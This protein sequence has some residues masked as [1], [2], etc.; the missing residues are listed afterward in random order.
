MALL[1]WTGIQGGLQLRWP[2]FQIIWSIR[3]GCDIYCWVGSQLT[4]VWIR[5][6]LTAWPEMGLY[7]VE[8]KANSLFS[9]KRAYSVGWES[10]H[11]CLGRKSAHCLVW[12]GFKSCRVG[13]RLIAWPEVDLYLSELEVNSS[14]GP[15]QANIVESEVDPSHIFSFLRSRV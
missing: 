10:I 2:G 5:G 15:E 11:S 13:N 9:P 7:L 4:I 3:S 6:Q 14:L 8:F 12:G 1:K